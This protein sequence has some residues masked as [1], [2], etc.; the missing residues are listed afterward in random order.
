[1]SAVPWLRLA[2][3]YREA[4]II[5]LKK[6]RYSDLRAMIGTTPLRVPEELQQLGCSATLS[7]VEDERR[8]LRVTVAIVGPEAKSMT[9]DGFRTTPRNKITPLY[10][11]SYDD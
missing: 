4:E 7:V 2:G 1:M 9:V 3:P 10:D 8:G 6:A 11:D 5:R